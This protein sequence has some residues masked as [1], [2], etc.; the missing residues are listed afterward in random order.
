[1]TLNQVA[2]YGYIGLMFLAF[3]LGLTKILDV[4][5]PEDGF[6]LPNLVYIL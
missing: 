4:Q 2:L 5:D 1:M 6:G 3:G